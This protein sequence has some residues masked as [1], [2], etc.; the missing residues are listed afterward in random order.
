MADM[1]FL[2]FV[3]MDILFAVC[4]GLLLAFALVAKGMISK[5]ATDTTIGMD[6]MMDQC[7]VQAVVANAALVF[8]AFA[9]SL[10]AL[11]L[12][13][14]RGWLKAFGYMVVVNVV[15]TLVIGLNIWVQTLKTRSNL[16]VVFEGLNDSRKSMLQ[17]E[18]SCCGYRN[19]TSPPFVRDNVCPNSV[20]ANQ[21]RPCIVPFTAFSNNTL[22]K[23]FTGAF[24]IVGIDVLVILA[25]AI[26][27]KDRK[28]QARYKVIDQ[29]NGG[30]GL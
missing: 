8:L 5:I 7:P 28:E 4:G 29:K 27:A 26:L 19:M 9:M 10:P 22:D 15:F 24:G 6:L 18:F 16:G 23:I 3:A 13:N 11:V 1:I 2:V 20:I 30:G 25:T 14:N 21:M 12:P 17:Q